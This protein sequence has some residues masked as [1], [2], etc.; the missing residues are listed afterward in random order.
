[1]Q[2][3]SAT[4]TRLLLAQRLEF[5]KGLSPVRNAVFMGTLAA[6]GRSTA[7]GNRFNRLI[8]DHR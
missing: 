4:S 8:D 7:T 1:M 3:P 5:Q 6:D 2:Q